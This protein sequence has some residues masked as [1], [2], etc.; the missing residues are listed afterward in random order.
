MQMLCSECG[1]EIRDNSLF[2][3]YCGAKQSEEIREN[4][5]VCEYCGTRQGKGRK[6]SKKPKKIFIDDLSEEQFN[7]LTDEEK[8]IVILTEI[9]ITN[10]DHWFYDYLT[11]DLLKRFD[12]GYYKTKNI[13]KN[14]YKDIL[15]I[16]REKYP[17]TE[18]EIYNKPTT[19]VKKTSQDLKIESLQNELNQINRRENRKNLFN[20]ISGIINLILAPFVALGNLIIFV[21]VIFIVVAICMIL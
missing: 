9:S 13:S 2:C 1:E 6:K 19:L 20:T 21:I 8:R 18:A 12:R 17:L 15:G 11:N 5:L 3:E 16:E 4:S 7:D 14:L 10:Q